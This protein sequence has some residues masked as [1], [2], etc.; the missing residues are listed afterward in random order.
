MYLLSSNSKNLTD[1]WHGNNMFQFERKHWHDTILLVELES[2]TAYTCLASISKTLQ[3]AGTRADF[4][5]SSS[6]DWRENGLFELE[7]KQLA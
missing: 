3:M 2:V 4:P 6:K 5:K 1:G 7:L